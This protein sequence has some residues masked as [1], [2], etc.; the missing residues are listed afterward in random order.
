ML[1]SVEI[2]TKSDW[3]R[4]NPNF[5]PS[6]L[7][8][9]LVPSVGI[10]TNPVRNPAKIRFWKSDFF[11]NWRRIL[12]RKIWIFFIRNSKN[13]KN[14]DL[15]YLFFVTLAVPEAS[16][17]KKPTVHGRCRRTDSFFGLPLLNRA[18]LYSRTLEL[19]CKIV[20]WSLSAVQIGESMKLKHWLYEVV[21]R[22][23]HKS[24][25]KWP[26]MTRFYIEFCIS[27]PL[28]W[29]FKKTTMYFSGIV[30]KIEVCG[31]LK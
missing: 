6:E 3:I 2:D 9:R 7:A 30:G 19:G 20:M 8:P 17:M 11:R 22:K 5:E 12:G 31:P 21:L 28:I 27:A 10:S 1:P 23:S 13:I 4:W 26:K 14:L 18:M 16:S 25:Q 24:G 29:H 15:K